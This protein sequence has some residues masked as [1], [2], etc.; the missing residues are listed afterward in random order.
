M[1]GPTSDHGEILAW[2]LRHNA[3]PAEVVPRIFDSEP[4][5]LH[6]L[7]DTARKGSP[8][9][10]PISWDSFFVQFDLMHLVMVFDDSPTFEILQDETTS[11]YRPSSGLI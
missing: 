7:F 5:I 8:E 2:A 4:A 9:I 6:F 3:V 1:F 10:R 11:I